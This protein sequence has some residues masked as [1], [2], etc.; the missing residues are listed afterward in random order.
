MY[1]RIWSYRTLSYRTFILLAAASAGLVPSYAASFILPPYAFFGSGFGGSTTSI[2]SYTTYSPNGAAFGSTSYGGAL[3]PSPSVSASSNAASNTTTVGTAVSNASASLQYYVE[4]LG[5]AAS[6]QVTFNGFGSVSG[7][8]T[9]PG[10]DQFSS[11]GVDA[12][13]GIQSLF[14]DETN[15][16]I[17]DYGGSSENNF[18][19][20][21]TN[22]GFNSSGTPA[23]GYSGSFS[24]TRTLTLLTGQSYLLNLQVTANSQGQNGMSAMAAAFVDPTFSIAS[25]VANPGQYSFQFSA[26]VGNSPLSQAPEPGTWATLG[27]SLALLATVR[28]R[29]GPSAL[30]DTQS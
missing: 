29:L 24:D 7:S 21:L 8:F 28:R 18:A 26:G 27:F 1:C 4:V 12:K 13:L 23:G 30:R 3:T 20:S 22:N 5:P 17:S 15:I 19:P 25:G 16:S 10:N 6:V 11:I 2:G 9:Q 14:L